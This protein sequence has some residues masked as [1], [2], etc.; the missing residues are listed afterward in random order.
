MVQSRRD[1]TVT[2]PAGKSGDLFFSLDVF[3]SFKHRGFHRVHLSQDKL[4]L[5]L[6]L[7]FQFMID[8]D[9]AL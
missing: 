8:Y 6:F 9:V 5:C 4:S 3:L 1:V 7:S 2:T